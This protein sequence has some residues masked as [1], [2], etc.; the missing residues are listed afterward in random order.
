VGSLLHPALV[1]D[2][3]R[4]RTAASHSAGATAAECELADAWLN[5]FQLIISYIRQIDTRIP[6]NDPVNANVIGIVWQS[7]MVG[8]N[9]EQQT[10]K[11]DRQNSTQYL[12]DFKCDILECASYG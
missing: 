1:V 5:Y 6:D 3:R 8:F 7:S 11:C 2:L 9:N 4:D 12:P 10:K